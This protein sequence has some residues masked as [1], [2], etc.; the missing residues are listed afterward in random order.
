MTRDDSPTNESARRCP[1]CGEPL[2]PHKI[3]GVEVDACEDHGVWLDTGELE[4]ILAKQRRTLSSKAKMRVQ[5]AR[6]E[7]KV[8]GA[9]WGWW[10]LFED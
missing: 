2:R 5:R 1:T 8:S 6:K 10:S 7:G 3:K 4:Q 9:L